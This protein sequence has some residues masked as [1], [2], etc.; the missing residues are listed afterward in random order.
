ML[1]ALV[2]AGSAKLSLPFALATSYD[3]T[4]TNEASFT[5]SSQIEA[6]TTK[7]VAIVLN[8]ATLAGKVEDLTKV[9][10]LEISQ[11]INAQIEASDRDGLMG[12]VQVGVGATGALFLQTTGYTDYG[13]DG[14]PGGE[15]LN[16]DHA[17]LA[18]GK[19]RTLAVNNT[20]LSGPGQIAVDIG[21]GTEIPPDANAQAVVDAY[22]RQTLESDAGAEDTG[23]RLALYF[24]RK[25]STL[26]SGYDILSD[27]AMTQVINTVIGLPAT[28]GATTSE[29]LAARVK[30]IASK[31]DFAS[32]QDPAKVE[33][34]TRRFAA[35]W[36]AQNNTASD[37]ILALFGVG[38]A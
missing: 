23:V 18:G 24:A 26:K 29:A 2:P 5:I 34:F 19:V 32:F 9:T 22:L 3:F 10:Q 13:L 8:R 20:A 11:A 36:D 17:Y 25:A 35:I 27:P 7:S 28:S 12:K 14:A 31:V 1:D 4:G 38:G 30:L 6:G 21:N 15:G 37:P 16:A 33:A